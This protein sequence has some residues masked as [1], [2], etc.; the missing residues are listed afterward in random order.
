MISARCTAPSKPHSQQDTRSKTNLQPALILSRPL[1]KDR[2]GKPD[3]SSSCA[4]GWSV[5][6]L[7]RATAH[8]NPPVLENTSLKIGVPVSFGSCAARGATEILFLRNCFRKK[9]TRS[10]TTLGATALNPFTRSMMI[11]FTFSFG[12]FVCFLPRPSPSF[13]NCGG[14]QP[15]GLFCE[16][17]V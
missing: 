11:L 4:I 12:A 3:T 13:D 8:V 2:T 16:S 9:A 10:C 7:Q 14:V 6:T 15:A 5:F 1:S 17:V